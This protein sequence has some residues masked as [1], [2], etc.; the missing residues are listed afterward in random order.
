MNLYQ[1]MKA[2]Q[3]DS[4]K[5]VLNAVEKEFTL[6]YA[7]LHFARHDL[8]RRLTQILSTIDLMDGSKKSSL[9]SEK[10]A[11]LRGIRDN[12]QKIEADIIT[13]I[14]LELEKVVV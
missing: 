10:M 12:L 7:G 14:Y 5:L 3:Q 2:T 8:T 6:T 11:Q 1:Q 13:E 9:V 4:D